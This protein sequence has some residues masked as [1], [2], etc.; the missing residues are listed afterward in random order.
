MTQSNLFMP[1][2][3][4]QKG[5]STRTYKI[6][7]AASLLTGTLLLTLDFMNGLNAIVAGTTPGISSMLIT[8]IAL[9]LI[10]LFIVARNRGK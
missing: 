1:K 7:G 5:P 8:G 4:A 10:G 9:I 6:V 3:T 2:K